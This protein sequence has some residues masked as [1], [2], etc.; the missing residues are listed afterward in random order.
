MNEARLTPLLQSYAAAPDPGLMAQLVE[1]YLPL[2]RAIARKFSGRGVEQEDLDQVAAMALMKAIERFEPDRGLKFSTFATPTIAG[3][4]RNYLRDKGSLMRMSRDSRSL[5]YKLQR[6][7]DDLTQQL[8]REPSIRE[9]ARAMSLSD[10][11][12]LAVLDARSA[13]EVVSFDKAVSEEEDA[14]SL[15]DFLGENERGYERVEARA[16][17]EW[18]YSQVT[19]TERRLLELRY[20]QRLGQR[21][22]ARYLGVS[23]MQV[24]RLERRI[25]TRLR[26][27]EE[28]RRDPT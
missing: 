28:N 25:L 24:S 19:P 18:V 5:L 26:Q 27:A 11:E 6:V 20:V 3:E 16:W 21:E 9:L 22:T 12:L 23:Q 14:A 13:T 2:S 4:V 17:M 7:R 10:D 8:Q 1:G 15:G